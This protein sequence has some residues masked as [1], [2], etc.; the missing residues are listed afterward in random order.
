MQRWGGK[1][2]TNYYHWV[3]G[4][5]L[6]KMMFIHWF[7]CLLHTIILETLHFNPLVGYCIY[8]ERE[9]ARFAFRQWNFS[10]TLLTNPLSYIDYSQLFYFPFL[11]TVVMTLY[12]LLSSRNCVFYFYVRWMAHPEQ[13]IRNNVKIWYYFTYK[14]YKIL[15]KIIIHNLIYTVI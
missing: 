14:L 2:R 9:L 1:G 15:F 5:D 11:L 7:L 6:C 12:F 13:L 8:S 10:I 4:M 3:L